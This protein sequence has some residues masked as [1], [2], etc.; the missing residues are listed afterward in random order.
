[1]IAR[2]I[3]LRAGKAYVAAG[4]TAF[5]ALGTALS[6]SQVSAAEFVGLLGSTLAA[7][8]ATYFVPNGTD[9]DHT[10]STPEV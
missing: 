4:V 1:M 7:F 8:G 5:A 9:P 2:K 6:D 10:T 3:G